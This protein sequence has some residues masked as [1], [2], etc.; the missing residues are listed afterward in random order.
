MSLSVQSRDGAPSALHPREIELGAEYRAYLFGHLRVFRHDS[1]MPLNAGGRRKAVEILEWFLLHPGSPCSAEQ[2][3]DMLWPEAD[4]EKALTNFHVSLHALR[5]ILEPDLGP[6]Q[7]STFIRRHAA[8]IY[9]FETGGRWWT[10]VDDLELLYQRGHECD[11]A[12]ETSRARFYYR[13]VAG[14]AARHRLLEGDSSPWLAPY[15]R[16][17]SIMC[18]HSLSRLMELDAAAGD[19]E[20]LLE[21]AYAMLRVDRYSEAAV[22]AIAL[23]HLRNDNTRQ[24]ARLIATFCHGLERDL[25]LRPSRDLLE[26][27]RRLAPQR[28]QLAP[29]TQR[30][31][32]AVGVSRREAPLH[33]VPEQ[34]LS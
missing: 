34:R 33:N 8:T 24:A 3:V 1:E 23:S 4:P 22:R 32:V 2:F 11:L 15:R 25:G 9:T 27:H 12:G 16:E 5:R 20:E 6:R 18:G 17:F 14:Y 29:V 19:Q 31:P 13:R 26:L 7:P 30:P 10:D 21:T 28:M